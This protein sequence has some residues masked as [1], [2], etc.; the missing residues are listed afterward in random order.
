[1]QN[2]KRATLKSIAVLISRDGSHET[3]WVLFVLSPAAIPAGAPRKNHTWETRH[4][5]GPIRDVGSAGHGESVSA[6]LRRRRLGE[7]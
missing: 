5:A 4:L 1:M 2:S 7:A 6:G 3:D